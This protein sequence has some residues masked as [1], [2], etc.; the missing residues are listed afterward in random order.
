MRILAIETATSVG[1]VALLDGHEVVREIIEQVPQRHLEWLAPAIARALESSG[2]GPDDVAGVAVSL[3]PGLFTGLRIGVATAAAWAYAR[4]VP[5]VGVSTLEV[6][7]AGTVAA[8]AEGLICPVLDARRGEVAFA[9]FE[10]MPRVV[11]VVGE[12]IGPVSALVDRMPEGAAI[13][14]SGDGI[15]RIHDAIRTR[16]RTVIAPEATWSPR[17]AFVGAIA[18]GRLAHGDHDDPS[19]LRPVYAR[20]AGIS[21]SPWIVV[22]EA[23]EGTPR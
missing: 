4:R 9:L 16:P 2:W 13:T 19:L 7:A 23:G 21:P 22:P 5:I 8:G 12:T 15:P 20:G 14:F 3:G 1:S 18:L 11:R 10:G 17:A 6:I